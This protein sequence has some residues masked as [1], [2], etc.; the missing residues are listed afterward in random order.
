MDYTR[1]ALS[2]S[3]D[4]LAQSS[5]ILRSSSLVMLFYVWLTGTLSGYCSV[6]PPS[7]PLSLPHHWLS[8][9]TEWARQKCLN[10]LIKS[11]SQG[12]E[13]LIS[14]GSETLMSSYELSISVHGC[15]KTF[16]PLHLLS[17]SLFL[18]PHFTCWMP[19]YLCWGS[20]NMSVN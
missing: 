5:G 13:P 7:L 14:S 19:P 10:I 11:E 2:H 20:V 6:S 4:S 3:E 15:W 9:E 16:H 18:L 12:A 17:A 1:S 8:G